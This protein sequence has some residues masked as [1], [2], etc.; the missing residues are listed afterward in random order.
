MEKPSAISFARE[1]LGGK[2]AKLKR[3]KPKRFKVDSRKA[4][5]PPKHSPFYFK[6]EDGVRFRS[7]WPDPGSILTSR[8]K[9][10]Y[11]VTSQGNYVRVVQAA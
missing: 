9:T 8:D 4:T 2:P 1:L 6:A 7:A 10:R 11:R 3:V 5:Q